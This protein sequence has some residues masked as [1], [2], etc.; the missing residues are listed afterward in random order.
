MS[1]RESLLAQQVQVELA[2][3]INSFNR[4][5]LL[6][7]A[8]P[9]VT[10][11]LKQTPIESAVIIFEAGSTDGSVQFIEDY[12][13]NIQQP[14]IICLCPSADTDRSFSA[15]CNFAVQFAAQ[16]FP[17]LKWCF[18][19]ETDNLIKNESALPLAMKLLEQEENLAAV[20]FTV[21]TY[22]G[23]K[24]GF[25][26]RFPTPLAFLV[27]QQLSQRLGLQQMKISQWHPFLGVR[28]GVSDV[29]FTSPLLVRYSAWQSTGGMDTARFPYSDCDSDWCWRVYEKGFRVAVLDVPGVIHDN[30]MQAS[31]WSGNRV[32][33]FH[34]ARFRLLLM[35]RGQGIVLLKPLLF[36]RHGLE[37]FLLI[38][39]SCCSE[40][41]TKSLENR[42]ILSKTV[43]KGYED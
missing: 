5:S 21:E 34:Q 27:G 37:F 14:Q 28:W 19:F 42:A 6:R 23:R 20:G 38:F 10:Q 32:I 1:E 40:R 25:G 35:H 36:L 16:K 11:A 39:I 4:L 15:G 41:A 33:N 24:A 3:I 13:A 22:D 7:E 12:S 29:V 9:S 2:V 8:L 43:F 30:K 26:S 31:A 18:F 17:R